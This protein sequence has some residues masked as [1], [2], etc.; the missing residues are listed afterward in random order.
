MGRGSLHCGS[1]NPLQTPNRTENFAVSYTPS[2]HILHYFSQ[3]YYDD[4]LAYLKAQSLNVL[5][6][7][8]V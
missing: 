4:F 2:K 1:K 3:V 7:N 5:P 6:H 8:S